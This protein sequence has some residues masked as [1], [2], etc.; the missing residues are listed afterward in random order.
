MTKGLENSKPER[1][2]QILALQVTSWVIPG[3]FPRS[4]A[5]L[6]PSAKIGVRR[7]K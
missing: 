6:A 4:Q 7:G 3:K 1:L 2:T 5:S